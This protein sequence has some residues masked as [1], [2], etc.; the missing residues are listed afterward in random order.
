MLCSSSN[1]NRPLT[2]VAAH[3]AHQPVPHSAEASSPRADEAAEAGGESDLGADGRGS[4]L[5]SDSGGVGAECVSGFGLRSKCSGA[6]VIAFS[7]GL[8]VLVAGAALVDAEMLSGGEGRVSGSVV[9][10]LCGMK[11]S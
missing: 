10:R 2:I 8:E 3:H 4:E 1:E 7:E 9:S 11:C 5:S 6:D